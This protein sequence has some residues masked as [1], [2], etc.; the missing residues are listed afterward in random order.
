MEELKAELREIVEAG[1][2]QKKG[3]PWTAE[4]RARISKGQDRAAQGWSWCSHRKAMEYAS[5]S[6]TAEAVADAAVSS[7]GDWALASKVW[8]T[9]SYQ[10]DGHPISAASST[11]ASIQ[12]ANRQNLAAFVMDVRVRKAAKQK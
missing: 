1:K 11:F 4:L 7:C 9:M 12:R 10:A 8:M 6:E 3:K 5:L 2:T